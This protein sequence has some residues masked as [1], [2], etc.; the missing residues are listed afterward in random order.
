VTLKKKLHRL[1]D[2]AVSALICP[3]QHWPKSGFVCI[4]ILP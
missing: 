2:L 4:L 3:A 1:Q